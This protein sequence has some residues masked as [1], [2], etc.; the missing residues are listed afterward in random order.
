MSFDPVSLLPSYFNGSQVQYTRPQDRIPLESDPKDPRLFY[1]DNAKNIE[2]MIDELSDQNWR[3]SYAY[4]TKLIRNAMRDGTLTAAQA[5]E[6]INQEIF[7]NA[8][9]YVDR[10][11]KEL[12]IQNLA[13][14]E[15]PRTAAGMAMMP[16]AALAS[17]LGATALGL[18]P[19]QAGITGLASA[20]AI[21]IVDKVLESP[22][23]RQYRTTAGLRPA[24][25]AIT[26][27][28]AALGLKTL[29]PEQDQE[30]LNQGMSYAQQQTNQPIN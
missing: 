22:N 11:N 8:S 21:P 27:I 12:A 10:E 9:H 25:A 24:V 30:L 5:D 23:L 1:K 16:V 4:Q 18:D 6:L 3:D 13:N 29:S 28:L 20:A 26:G 14:Y 17:G 2:G 19:M 7:K 15:M